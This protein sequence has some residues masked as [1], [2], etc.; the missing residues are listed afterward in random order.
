MSIT[1]SETVIGTA[2]QG[3]KQAKISPFRELT[4][5]KQ[6]SQIHRKSNGNKSNWGKL[7]QR[8]G[9]GKKLGAG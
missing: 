2:S 9:I 5:N 6:I 1:S 4:F 3:T 8:K 7:R